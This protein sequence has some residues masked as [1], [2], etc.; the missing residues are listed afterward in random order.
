MSVRLPVPGDWTHFPEVD[1]WKGEEVSNV[2]KLHDTNFS[3]S[4]REDSTKYICAIYKNDE[5]LV[6]RSG[7]SLEW[8]MGFL[9][10]RMKEIAEH[11]EVY[12]HGETYEM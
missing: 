8:A 10:E 7:N 1:S 5:V 3:A 4:V 9:E 2:W 6:S 12:P 11:G